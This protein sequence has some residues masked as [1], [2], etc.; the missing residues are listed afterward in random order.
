MTEMVKCTVNGKF[1]IVLPKHR[2]DRP[3][4]YREAGWEK[5]RMY[6][7]H[8]TVKPGDIV[9]YVGT[10]EG[11]MAAIIA[12]WGAK[13]LLFEP[14]DRVWPNV[15][16]I[17]EANKLDD[18]LAVFSGFAANN[19][20]LKGTKIQY[21]GF[22]QSADGPVIGDHGFKEL[23][24]EAD[25][26]PQVKI[27]DVVAESNLVPNMISLDVEG[28]EWE[29]LRGAEVT[30]REHR[31]DIYLSLHP[32]FMFRMFNEYSYD[33]RSWIKQIGYE[34]TLLDYQ[35]EVHFYYTRQS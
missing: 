16:V 32:E 28:S 7:M 10:E 13:L 15:K 3:D 27:D 29:V 11:D 17:W 33:F 31:P 12:T 30:M 9:Y 20:D 14:N 5:K 35:H 24:Y 26:I 8:E 19:T 1:G 25:V 23:A 4:W 18:P 6:S 2:A 22:P 34:E 21:G